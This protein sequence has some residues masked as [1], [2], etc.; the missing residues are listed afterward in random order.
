MQSQNMFKIGDVVKFKGGSE[1]HQSVLWVVESF[2][3]SGDI[4]IVYKEPGHTINWCA[5]PSQIY[6]PNYKSWD[7]KPSKTV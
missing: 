3:K 4:N 1:D 5:E 7:G 2:D 6:H